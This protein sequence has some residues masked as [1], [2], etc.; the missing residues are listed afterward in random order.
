MLP[1]IRVAGADDSCHIPVIVRKV[2]RCPSGGCLPGHSVLVEQ[3]PHAHHIFVMMMFTITH[4]LLFQQAFGSFHHLLQTFVAL[5]RHSFG[6]AILRLGSNRTILQNKR[7]GTGIVIYM[8]VGS[9]STD[10]GSILALPV[11]FE[12]HQAGIV[13]VDLIEILGVLPEGF[14][15]FRSVQV[16][17]A[18]DDTDA[19][20]A[21]SGVGHQ[22]ILVGTNQC[23]CGSHPLGS[24]MVQVDQGIAGPGTDMFAGLPTFKADGN[25]EAGTAGLLAV[26][27]PTQVLLQVVA[28]FLGAVSQ[29]SVAF[30]D[31]DYFFKRSFY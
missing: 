20:P 14:S 13:V 4:S 11:A 16:I 17:D 26:G 28:M 10:T 25:S 30:N 12:A 7:S 3:I 21:D 8:R 9:Q 27:I 18:A 23:Q 22:C 6:S 5:C 24:D 1:G 31:V 19:M 2:L 15:L 29:G